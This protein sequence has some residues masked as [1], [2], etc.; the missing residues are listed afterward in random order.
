M[1][2]NLN[3]TVHD[4]KRAIKVSSVTCFIGFF[5]FPLLVVVPIVFYIAY[6]PL[7]V[8]NDKVSFP[9]NDQFRTFLDILFLN[10]ITGYIRRRSYYTDEILSVNNGYTR[11]IS[12]KNKTR[13]WNV[14]L[15]G[16][17]RDG[18]SWSQRI[19]C[20]SKQTRDEVRTILKQVIAG[21]VSSEFSY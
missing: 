1:N 16:I 5:V 13:D 7:R 3:L 20:G 11:P 21:K 6:T 17:T 18:K 9:A 14:V 2:T 12:S 8:K 19:D 4:F 15:S 10:P